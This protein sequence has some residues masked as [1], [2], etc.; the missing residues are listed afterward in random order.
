MLNRAALLLR[1]K[2]PFIDWINAVDPNPGSHTVTL[3][4]I[5]GEERT[6]YLVEVEDEQELERWL[7]L[8]AEVLFETELHDWYTD[9]S[10]WPNRTLDALRK[11]CS[12][13]LRTVVIDTGQTVLEDDDL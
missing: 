11:W 13:E 4:E 5:N 1:Y 12:L 9:P 6:V 3:D 7:Q 2:Q 8:N 10:L